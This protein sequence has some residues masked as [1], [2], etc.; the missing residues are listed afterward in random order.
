ME[1]ISGRKYFPPDAEP[2]FL[3]P[4]AATAEAA[5]IS[6]K[7]FF[8]VKFSPQNRKPEMAGRINPNEYTVTHIAV[9]PFFR[10]AV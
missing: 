1:I 7:K 5:R 3:K 9:F 8:D 2:P 10:A 6:P 4:D